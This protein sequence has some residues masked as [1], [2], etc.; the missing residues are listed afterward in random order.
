MKFIPIF[1]VFLFFTVTGC[2]E[3]SPYKD[4]SPSQLLSNPDAFEGKTICING[5]VGN[6]S[7]SGIPIRKTLNFTGD[8]QDWTLS[9][10]CGVFKDNTL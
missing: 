9:N 1:L 4:V 7:I 3:T 2:L 6:N 8:Y 5:I 10:V